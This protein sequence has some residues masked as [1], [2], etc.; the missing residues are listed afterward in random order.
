VVAAL[1][2]GSALTPTPVP[3][4]S[5]QLATHGLYRYCRHPIYSGILVI[6]AGLVIGSGNLW[7]VI[8]GAITVTFFNAKASWEETRLTRHFSGY[9]AYAATTPRFL[10]RIRAGTG[11]RD[12]TPGH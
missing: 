4:S 10:P 3:R 8:V 9:S 2:L 12:P 6:V 5:G 11:P 7:S 1:G